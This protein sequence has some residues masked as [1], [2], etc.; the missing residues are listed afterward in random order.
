MHALQLILWVLFSDKIQ[1]FL[2]SRGM[3]TVD[4]NKD[5]ERI[6]LT[7][8]FLVKDRHL[9][10][11]TSQNN[12]LSLVQKSSHTPMCLTRLYCV[13]HVVLRSYPAMFSRLFLSL[14]GHLCP[15]LTC[16]LLHV[17]SSIYNLFPSSLPWRHLAYGSVICI[18][19]QYICA[20][21]HFLAMKHLS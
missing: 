17:C 21:L 14:S 9:F 16:S 7:L 3:Q 19:L 15:P 4:R 6:W 18:Q 8:F 13:E 12:T 1:S 10:T 2:L 11:C 20:L 5:K